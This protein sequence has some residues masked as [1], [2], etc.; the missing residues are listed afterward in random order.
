MDQKVA[1]RYAKALFLTAQKRDLVQSVED[2]MA[3][4]A[5]LVENNSEFRGFLMSPQLAREEKIQ[6]AERLFSDRVTALTMQA[7]RLLLEKRR[8]VEFT[9]VREEFVRLR[10]EQGNVL[11]AVVTSADAMDEEQKVTLLRKLEQS[12][13]KRV[14]AEFGID[15]SLIGGI[16]V[17]YGNFVLD[18]SVRGSLNRLKTTLRYDVLKRTG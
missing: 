12:S 8:E 3:A 10:R 4:I 2:D 11:F 5:N 7:L 6:I 9:A 13:G 16:R 14:E 1:A 17:A 18:G 15:R